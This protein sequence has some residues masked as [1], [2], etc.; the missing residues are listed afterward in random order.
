MFSRFDN[1]FIGDAG[2]SSLRN[3]EEAPVRLDVG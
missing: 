1:M 3:E 2:W